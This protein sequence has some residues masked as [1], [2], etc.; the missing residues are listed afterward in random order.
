MSPN[1]HHYQSVWRHSRLCRPPN[2]QTSVSRLQ[3]RWCRADW[4]PSPHSPHGKHYQQTSSETVNMNLCQTRNKIY[5]LFQ[6]ICVV[7]TQKWHSSIMMYQLEHTTLW[8]C[9]TA[10]L[11]H[12]TLVPYQTVVWQGMPGV[13]MLS[14]QVRSGGL[15]DISKYILF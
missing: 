2:C 14:H 11:W 10:S 7:D 3:S 13:I 12:L 1:Q 8:H 9:E 5:L 4:A 15:S 6:E